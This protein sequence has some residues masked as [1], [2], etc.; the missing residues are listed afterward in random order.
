[1]HSAATARHRVPVGVLTGQSGSE[2]QVVASVDMPTF[3][4]GLWELGAINDV[5]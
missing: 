5:Q 3:W 2:S 1:M 4:S